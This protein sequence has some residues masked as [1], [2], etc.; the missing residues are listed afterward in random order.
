MPDFKTLDD[1]KAFLDE[2]GKKFFKNPPVFDPE[3]GTISTDNRPGGMIPRHILRAHI[4]DTSGGVE[5]QFL[6][7][8]KAPA[9]IFF[10]YELGSG[11]DSEKDATY[12]REYR[13]EMVLIDRQTREVVSE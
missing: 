13:L 1:V 11:Y 4:T 12:I 10:T 6:H 7:A 3:K 8:T 9:Q 2:Q 5:W